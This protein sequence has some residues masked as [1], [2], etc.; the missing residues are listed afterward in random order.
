MK[1]ARPHSIRLFEWSQYAIFGLGLVNYLLTNER[2]RELAA[3]AGRGPAFIVVTA[4]LTFGLLFLFV[5]LIAYRR[6]SVAKWI[7]VALNALGLLA[8]LNLTRMMAQNG[9]L[10]ISI[11]VVQ[12]SLQLFS[13]WMLFR[14]DARDW[15]A[16]KPSVDSQIFG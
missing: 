10:S 1:Q 5:W 3:T 13:I 14:R 16:G 4:L 8:F 2:Q 12:S 9:A 7:F 15:L 6:S 11:T